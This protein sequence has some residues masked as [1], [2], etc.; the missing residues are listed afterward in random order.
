M[1]DPVLAS[2]LAAQDAALKGTLKGA[3]EHQSIMTETKTQIGAITPLMDNF[4]SGY[5]GS[6]EVA[7]GGRFRASAPESTPQPEPAAPSTP[8]PLEQ[9]VLEAEAAKTEDVSEFIANVK[10]AVAEQ[11]QT[12]P[13]LNTELQKPES[14]YNEGADPAQLDAYLTAQFEVIKTK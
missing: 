12:N 5:A 2:R 3:F 7:E 11:R 10:T 8:G 4:N 1:S 13:E 14:L 9:Q 6:P